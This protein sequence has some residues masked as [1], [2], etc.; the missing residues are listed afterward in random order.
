MLVNHWFVLLQ[1]HMGVPYCE[2]RPQHGLSCLRKWLAH[3]HQSRKM[4]KESL[5]VLI[6][7]LAISQFL[8]VSFPQFPQYTLTT[9]DSRP[10]TV[11]TLR[12]G[13]LQQH[14]V[15]ECRLRWF[16]SAPESPSLHR[17]LSERPVRSVTQSY[18]GPTSRELF[19]YKYSCIDDKMYIILYI[20]LSLSLSIAIYCKRYTMLFIWYSIILYGTIYI[21]I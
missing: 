9:A 5:Y 2:Q 14:G 18:P 3:L 21:Y 13:G 1:L 16:C 15:H 12:K 20:Y 8:S 11:C 10:K 6:P 7:R 17:W 4:M 19:E